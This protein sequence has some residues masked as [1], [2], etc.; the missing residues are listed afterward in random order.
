M[1]QRAIRALLEQVASGSVPV[2]EALLKLKM[3]P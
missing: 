3:E 2:D 1:E